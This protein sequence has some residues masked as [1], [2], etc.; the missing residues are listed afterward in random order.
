M[1]L[2]AVGSPGR[3]GVLS[4]GNPAAHHGYRRHS[5]TRRCID[6]SE[7]LSGA[8]IVVFACRSARNPFC[9]TNEVRN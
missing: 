7:R 8:T 9:L 4:F 5:G 6:P 2:F 1:Q 3:S